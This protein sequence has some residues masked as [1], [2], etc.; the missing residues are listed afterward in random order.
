VQSFPLDGWEQFEPLLEQRRTG[1]DDRA[2]LRE[3]ESVFADWRDRDERFVQFVYDAYKRRDGSKMTNEDIDEIRAEA[4]RLGLTGERAKDL[5]G[6]A[7]RR[8]TAPRLGKVLSVA[9]PGGVELKL[10]YIPPGTFRMGSPDS[11]PGRFDNEG[12]QH[13]VTLTKGFY[14]GIDPVTQAQWR[15]VMG[16]NPS[17][18]EGKHHPIENVTWHE[19]QA[20][21]RKLG[22]LTGRVFRLPTEAEWEYACR[23]GTTTAYSFG[24]Q[25]RTVGVLGIGARDV[26]GQF[27][28]YDLNSGN[29]S[30]PVGRKEPNAWGLYDMH[31]QVAEWCLDG[32]R[33]YDSH[34]VIDPVGPQED[35]RRIMRGGSWC[36]AARSLR[37]AARSRATPESRFDNVG[38]RVVCVG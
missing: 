5:A 3:A 30:H 10:T 4:R 26:L 6:E 35:D 36:K 12:P 33:T 27:A 18:L 24:E 31:G 16:N 8:W 32:A 23:A 14:M 25:A 37:S 2:L 29:G 21:C 15:A 13:E 7:K 20:F 11:E 34:P 17:A 22:E 9:L 28:W 1:L 38:C 19:C